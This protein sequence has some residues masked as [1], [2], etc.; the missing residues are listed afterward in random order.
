[1]LLSFIYS[2]HSHVRCI[3]SKVKIPRALLFL[4]TSRINFF[5]L[6]S[7]QNEIF[8]Y[9]LKIQNKFAVAIHSGT[10]EIFDNN[11]IWL[12][13]TKQNTSNCVIWRRCHIFQLSIFK[14]ISAEKV[15][16]VTFW[17]NCNLQQWTQETSS[18]VSLACQGEFR[19]VL[20]WLYFKLSET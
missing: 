18:E 5:F 16:E 12:T 11:N 14:G 10:E 17:L 4:K 6:R 9:I 20:Y 1:M 19:N 15:T 13:F 7:N 8:K 3:K 2:Y